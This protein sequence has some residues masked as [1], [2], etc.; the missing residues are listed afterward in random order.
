MRPW[1]E[2]HIDPETMALLQ[3]QADPR[4]DPEACL[5]AIKSGP[6][7]ITPE[8]WLVESWLSALLFAP[9]EPH[10]RRGPKPDHHAS[11]VRR[12]RNAHRLLVGQA[13]RNRLGSWLQD[14]HYLKVLASVLNDRRVKGHKRAAEIIRRMEAGSRRWGGR[15][16]TLRTVRNHIALFDKTKGQQ[17][18]T[19]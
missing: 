14:D 17:G 11:A 5:N 8:R 16:P 7:V 19:G 13:E 18:E 9:P 10:G 2:P 6:G 1:I 15:L 12:R 4:H 3:M